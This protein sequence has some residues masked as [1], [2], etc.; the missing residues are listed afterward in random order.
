MLN[1]CL[2]KSTF[3]KEF[4][5]FY[6]AGIALWIEHGPEKQRVTGVI[7]SQGTCLGVGQVPSRGRARSNH[8]LMFLTLSLSLPLSLKIK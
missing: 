7:P 6:L 1:V 8:T 4:V 2:I 5:V 3:L